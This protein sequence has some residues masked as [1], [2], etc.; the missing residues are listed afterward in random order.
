MATNAASDTT[1]GVTGADGPTYVVEAGDAFSAIGDA[2]GVTAQQIADANDWSDG[3][4]HLIQPGQTIRLP[5]GA[6]LRPGATTV[7]AR[8]RRGRRPRPRARAAP[9][10]TVAAAATTIAP[11]SGYEPVATPQGPE[12]SAPIDAS[13]VQPDG[14]L[15]G[16]TDGQYWASAYRV[17]GDGVEFQ[18]NQVF[19]DDACR[20]R[21]ATLPGGCEDG[22][23]TLTEPTGTITMSPT[24]DDVIVCDFL[25]FPPGDCYRVPGAEFARLV[26]G[27]PSS[28]GAPADFEYTPSPVFVT[29]RD[30]AVTAVAAQFVS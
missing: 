25:G 26:A 8:R 22:I 30:G 4:G 28:A 6:A 20:E 13:W 17:A 15:H 9:S 7:G 5:A 29:V 3:I 19:F 2:Y 10:T 23:H 21:F 11:A 27:G 18:L 16:I 1:D 14:T 24:V 12:R